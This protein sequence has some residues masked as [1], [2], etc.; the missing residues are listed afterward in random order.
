[1]AENC[2]ISYTEAF[3]MNDVDLGIAN[4]ALDKMKKLREKAM[5]KGGKK[6]R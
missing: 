5:K 2:N 3:A 4:A 1:M 6:G